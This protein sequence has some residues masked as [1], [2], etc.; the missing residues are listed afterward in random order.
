MSRSLQS[1]T[2]R[3]CLKVS[4]LHYPMYI[5]VNHHPSHHQLALLI[6]PFHLIAR[7]L[8]GPALTS[9]CLNFSAQSEFTYCDWFCIH[10]FILRHTNAVVANSL[11]HYAHYKQL[12]VMLYLSDGKTEYMHAQTSSLATQHRHLPN[13]D[14]WH[15]MARSSSGSEICGRGRFE[16]KGS[17]WEVQCRWVKWNIKTPSRHCCTSRV[18]RI[19]GRNVSAYLLLLSPS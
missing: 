12:E 16:E 19:P 10:L 9:M 2:F 4:C 15:P 7:F 13:S 17:A 14:P 11:S 18:K 5:W 3:L 6:H 1:F 8:Y